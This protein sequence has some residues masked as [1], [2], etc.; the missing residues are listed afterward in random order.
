VKTRL[1]YLIA[2]LFLLNA[3]CSTDEKEE[4]VAQPTLLGSWKQSTF[5]VSGCTDA[6]GD[7]EEKCTGTAGDC[8]VLTITESSW[9][10]VQNLG[11]GSQFKESGGYTLSSNYIILSGATSPGLGKYSITGSTVSYTTTTLTFVN[12]S[13]DTGCI[14]TVTFSRHL[15]AGVPLG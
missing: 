4:P 5:V 9:T 15:Q 6:G 11:D 3:A 2:T 10:W 12:S 14:Y 7:R 1:Y 13:V 8:G